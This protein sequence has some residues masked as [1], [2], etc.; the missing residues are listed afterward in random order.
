MLLQHLTVHIELC[1]LAGHG[2]FS[3]VVT[4]SS[5][6]HEIASHLLTRKNDLKY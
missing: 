4:S 1:S 3:P 5:S 2:C 6:Q